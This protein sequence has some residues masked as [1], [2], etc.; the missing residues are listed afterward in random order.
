M[1]S[2]A[3]TREPMPVTSVTP[4]AAFGALVR[5]SGVALDDL[6]VER[7]A[8]YRDRLHQANAVTNLTAVRD[9]ASID[10]RLILES[11]RL[12]APIRA[13]MEVSS[14]RRS[15]L[16]IGT[17]GGVPGMVLA[18]ALPDVQVFLLDATGKKVAFLDRAIDELG[19]TNA[20]T[21]HARAEELGHNPAY[22][23]AFD[24]VTARA[25]ATVPVLLELGLPFLKQGGHLVLPK[26]AGIERELDPGIRAAAIL[27]GT[28]VSWNLLPAS[29]S[30][31][32]TRL[33]IARKTSPTPMAFPRRTGLPAR[34]PLGLAHPSSTGNPRK[35]GDA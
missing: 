18:I 34:S 22:R 10:R 14:G 8:N 5:S 1:A 17:G 13:G 27:G 7:L 29:E 30:G 35:G 23:K 3:T 9:P 11:L 16:D 20:S 32:E 21:I 2:S 19:L 4:E 6:Q 15:L 31:I 26:G 28:L 12:V 25:V 33:V 24:V